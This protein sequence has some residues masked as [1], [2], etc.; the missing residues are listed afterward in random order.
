MKNGIRIGFRKSSQLIVNGKHWSK[1]DRKINVRQRPLMLGALPLDGLN[2]LSI[3][4]V[5]LLKLVVIEHGHVQFAPP[6]PE[7]FHSS[8]FDAPTR[9][10][11]SPS[12]LRCLY[13]RPA[14]SQAYRLVRSFCLMLSRRD[15][16]RTRANS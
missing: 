10:A 5:D 11:R 2:A 13:P 9:T 14:R 7:L 1:G 4:C 16:A 6:A 8:P 12:Y 15:Q 3:D